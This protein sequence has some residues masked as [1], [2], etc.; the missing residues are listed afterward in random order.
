[1]FQYQ[2]VIFSIRAINVNCDS[3]LCNVSWSANADVD[4]CDNDSETG[5]IECEYENNSTPALPDF[6][7]LVNIIALLD[8][9]FSDPLIVQLPSEASNFSGSY[10]HIDSGT[11][12]PLDI[13][14]GLSSFMA[15]MDIT[16]TAE[17]GTQ[18]VIIDLPEDAP[19]EG[20]F[21][22]NFNYDLPPD[23]TE[24]TIKPM[25]T[26]KVEVDD[27]TFYPPTLPCVTSFA[28]IPELMFTETDT[29]LVIPPIAGAGCDNV[30]YNFSGIAPPPGAA[31]IPTLSEWGLIAMAVILGLVGLIAIK[32][33]YSAA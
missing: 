1:M 12:G 11:G 2:V 4:S 19:T 16:I 23:T 13:T 33:K 32:K 20:E 21:A 7:I 22:F 5:T 14:S 31:S 30:A 24:F 17:P 8:I 28:D 18:I 15:D 6:S 9:L 10:A 25:F 3:M 26:G 27:E 29:E